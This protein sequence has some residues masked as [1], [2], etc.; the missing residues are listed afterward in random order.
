MERQ[1]QC[2]CLYRYMYICIC[3]YVL[4]VYIH[5]YIY[6][7]ID[8][9]IFMYVYACVCM[10]IDVD[11]WR[12]RSNVYVY[13]CI[14][15][16][17]YV[18]LC[19]F[20]QR[21]PWKTRLEMLNSIAV[22]ILNGGETW[23]NCKFK[24]NKNLIL[25][26]YSEISRNSNPIKISI[27]L[28]TVRYRDIWFSGFWLVDWN[29]PSIQDFD[30]HWIQHFESHFPRNALYVYTSMYRCSYKRV[31]RPLQC[32]RIHWYTYICVCIFVYV[33]MCTHLCMDIDIDI[34]MYV[35]RP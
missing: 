16:F 28:C 2:P 1:L 18:Y 3:V 7:D 6:M 23:V 26:L 14:C 22:E 9:Q 12:D 29:L 35:Y 19:M 31:E 21:V 34:F 27:R 4:C 10:D 17:V 32:L 24:F 20:I 33:Y 11:I 30:Y 8:I 25:S 15:T 13:K 5:I